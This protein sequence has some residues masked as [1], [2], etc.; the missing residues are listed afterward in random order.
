MAYDYIIIGSGFGGSVSALR[1]AEKGFKVCV[2]E[3]GKRWQPEDFPKT[4]WK[5]WKYFWA[6]AVRCFGFQRIYLLND[7]LVLG[8]SGVGGGSLVYANTLLEPPDPFFN[9][10]QWRDLENDWKNELLPH[11]A[12]AKKML[13]VVTNPKFW[14]TDYMLEEYAAEIGR[15]DHF[16]PAEV[17]V[18]FGKS[19]ETVP[20]PYFGGKGPPRSGC[21]QT[22]HCMVGCRDGGKNSLDKNYLYLAE[23]LGVDIF[24]GQKVIDI[25]PDGDGYIII[26]QETTR[27]FTNYK[28]EYKTRGVVLSAGVLGTVELLLRCKDNGSL[29]GLSPYLGQKVRTNSEVLAGVTAKKKDENH[30]MGVSITS[31]LFVNENTHI[32][33]VRYPKG[34]D[35][36]GILASLITDG[37]GK[38][39]RFLKHIGMCIRHPILF[40]RTLWP[41]G[42]GRKSVILL[43]MQSLDNFLSLKRKRC[44]WAPF[45]KR[46]VSNN[47]G[48]KIPTYIPE[49]NAAVRGMAQKM[50]GIPQNALTEVMLNIPMTAHILGGCTMGA[51]PDRGVIDKYHR[52]F[53]YDNMFVIDAS[54]IPA[55]L[56]INPS[57]T[58]TAMAERAMSY[59]PDKTPQ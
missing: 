22:G 28:Y 54:A 59:I 37:G 4:N 53:G 31:S 10:P 47:D 19:G 45:R 26:A 15:K 39:P 25:K 34:S 41:F 36:M 8:G 24:S 23:Q 5:F 16:K 44:W 33:L 2:I 12:T 48:K 3:S 11:Y 21:T 40:L 14:P 49:A 18:F 51:D 35:I 20:D 13:G 46:L 1:L 57:L 32:E 7:V 6:P 42:W 50:N 17:G 43:V 29:P 56:G 30:S 38:I 9:D 27:R 55:N 58:I 52:V